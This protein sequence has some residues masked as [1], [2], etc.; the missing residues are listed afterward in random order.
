M[1]RPLFRPARRPAPVRPWALEPQMP[2]TPAV[3][4]TP[5][6]RLLLPGCGPPSPDAAP[7]F[8][9]PPA[10][11]EAPQTDPA[12]LAEAPAALRHPRLCT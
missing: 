12:A 3:A 4:A 9:V 11:L 2:Q 8:A 6:R 5:P 1:R 7:P 10:P